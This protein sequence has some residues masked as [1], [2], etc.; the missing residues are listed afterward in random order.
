[1]AWFLVLPV[2]WFGVALVLGLLIGRCIRVER[3]EETAVL[4]STAPAAASAAGSSGA[5][6]PTAVAAAGY[7]E[8]HDPSFANVG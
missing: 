5:D 3:G 2:A 6:S 8:R 7:A 1:M 4:V